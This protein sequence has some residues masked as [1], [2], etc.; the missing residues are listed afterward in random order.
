MSINGQNAEEKAYEAIIA[1]I[2]QGN[3][4]PG[5]RITELELSEKLGVSRTPIR[6][7]LRRLIAEG[8]LERHKNRA[9]VIPSIS[10]KDMEDLFKVRL[11]IEPNIAF[12]AAKKATEDQYQYFLNL[13]EKE[14]ECYYQGN[15]AIYKIN[16]SLHFGIARLTQN[17]YME[18][19]VRHYYWRSE[20][21]VLF[22]DSFFME[23]DKVKLLRDPDK[24][25]SHL[26][27][28]AIIKS[29][30]DNRPDQSKMLMEDHILSTL[31]ML[32][33]HSKLLKEYRGG[34]FLKE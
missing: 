16:Q 11:M 24:S 29:I 13:L 15:T 7:A 28:R 23:T 26:E 31:S 8:L 27:H 32:N 9:Y 2:I 20:L 33:Y 10:K 17:R 5:S 1:A 30:F 34:D 4:A 22:F 21:Y 18:D 12:E 14:R 3:L 6:N 19:I 25:K